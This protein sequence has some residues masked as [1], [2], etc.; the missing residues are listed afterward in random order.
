M[1]D[2][3][4]VGNHK[5]AFISGGG[6]AI[7]CEIAIQLDKAGYHLL[8][9]DINLEKMTSIVSKLKRKPELFVCDQ[10]NPNEIQSLIETIKEKY[11]NID[12]L[13]NNAGYTKEGPFI[14]QTDTDIQRQLW[15]N[16]I[17]P[18]KLIHGIL[19]LM[20]K[21]GKGSI[22]SIVSVGGIIALADSSIYS[23][24]KFGL[25]GFLTALYE[26]VKH[27]N[28]KVSGIYPSAV[29]TP[30]LLHEALNG[31]TALNWINKVQSPKKVA[32][33]VLLGIKRGTLEI[34]VPYSDGLVS[35][36]V[37]VFPWLIGTLSPILK[38][39]GERSKRKWLAEKGIQIPTKTNLE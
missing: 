13:I 31:G 4:H 27:T 23:A 19:P 7:A 30:M 26:E 2:T 33:A 18:I 12:V 37:A 5:L 17:S 20:L 34:Y 21:R 28:I 36:L 15:I 16:L 38:W 6:G 14:T 32:D 22:V 35:R 29:D 24:G 3:N 11:P 1:T 8:L 25:R 39:I 9:S 10:T